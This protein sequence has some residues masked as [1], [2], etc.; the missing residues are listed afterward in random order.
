MNT[1]KNFAFK[2]KR[3]ILRTNFDVPLD[4]K[5]QIA[6]DFRIRR[7]LPTIKYLI[8]NEAK[9]ILISHLGRPSEGQRFSLEPVAVRLEELLGKKV[10]FV[11][12]CVGR[13]V[14]KAI[15]NMEP[16]DV[17]L[18]ENLRFHSGEINNDAHFAK[19]LASLGEIYINDAFSNCHRE[20]ASI[21]GIHKHLPSVVGLLL[22]EEIKILT[23]VLQKPK[24]PL[25]AVL[26]G[27][28]VETK[29]PCLMNLL[30]SADHIV[31]GGKIAPAILAA[32]RISISAIPLD[33]AAEK[34]LDQLELTNPKLHLPVDALV[35]LR[36]HQED[37]LRQAAVGKIRNEEQ[38]FD[39][40]PETVRIFSDIIQE[41]K[42]IIWNGP[43]GY[44]EDER[45]AG[46]S[47]AIT[48]AILRSNA[49]SVV[50]G[51]DTNAFLA[52]NNLRGKFDY[53]STGG[54][55]MLDF[56]SGKKLPGIKV[57]E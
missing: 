17:I 11:K 29:I 51:G 53:V 31:V 49:F 15:K 12:D 25:V 39:I 56:L 14:E 40:G 36:N 23:S 54:G 24:R 19:C 55:A 44:V 1:L 37:Y 57:L 22:E 13:M 46:G 38:M 47:L 34:E 18:L 26:G 43:L 3:V 16:G 10:M 2:D 28:K 21:V 9:V 50:G 45:F 27:A 4:K 6:D 5:G 8:D 7:G 42:T 33:E 20:H 48:N 41:A 35:G 32:K 30:N 52:E